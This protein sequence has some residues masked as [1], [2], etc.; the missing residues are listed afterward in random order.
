M[1]DAVLDA[2]E[3][4]AEHDGGGGDDDDG[5]RGHQGGERGDESIG[6]RGEDAALAS[7]Q[8]SQMQTPEIAG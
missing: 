5:A 8:V 4:H 6:E 3:V 7:K 1:R 2:A